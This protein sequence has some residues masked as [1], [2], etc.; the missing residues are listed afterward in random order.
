MDRRP[1]RPPVPGQL[2]QL[3][4][5]DRSTPPAAQQQSPQLSGPVKLETPEQKLAVQKSLSSSVTPIR[6][7]NPLPCSVAPCLNY[8]TVAQVSFDLTYMQYRFAPVCPVCQK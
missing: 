3:P 2:S 4:S 8:T 6:I 5:L 7:S 1:P